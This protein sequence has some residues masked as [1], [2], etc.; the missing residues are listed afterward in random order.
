MFYL[1]IVMAGKFVLSVISGALPS[2]AA[3]LT[4]TKDPLIGPY[5]RVGYTIIGGDL[6]EAK[7]ATSDLAQ[8][9]SVAVS[10]T[11]SND[12]TDCRDGRT[13]LVKPPALAREEVICE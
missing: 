4:D 5:F 8:K 13:T 9:A 7:N 3:V 12:T 1:R 11:M 10:E 2:A 6:N